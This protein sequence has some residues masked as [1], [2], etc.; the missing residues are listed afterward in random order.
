MK[1]FYFVGGPRE[2]QL[3]E[4]RRRLQSIGGTPPTWTI[5]PH[6]SADGNALHVVRADS[7]EEIT[8]HLQH[9][10]GIYDHSQ[11]IEIQERGR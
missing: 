5:Y 4:F 8:A 9:F 3:K 7:M 2:A 10:A 1:L 11:I 6:A